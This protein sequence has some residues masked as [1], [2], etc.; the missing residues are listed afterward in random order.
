[1]SYDAQTRDKHR[2]TVTVV[3]GAMTVGAL[4]ATGWMAGNAARDFEREQAEQQ[5]AQE[6]AEARANRARAR[7]ERLLARSGKESQQLRERPTR[8]R[9]TTHYVTGDTPSAPVVNAPPASDP[10][11]RPAPAPAPAPA[12]PPPPAPE[13]PPAPSSGS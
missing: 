12:V 5:A 1:M 13:P 9:V 8:T 7:Y 2:R 10:A 3:T 11:P 4:S 6:R